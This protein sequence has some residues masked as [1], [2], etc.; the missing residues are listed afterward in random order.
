MNIAIIGTGIAG[1]Y[2]AYRLAQHHDITVFEASDRIGGHTN[3]L[4]VEDAGRMLAVDTGFIVYND[5]TYP[6][7]IA[8]LDELGVASQPSDMSFSVTGGPHDLEYNGSSLNGLFAQRRNLVRPAFY[9]MLVDILR[10]NREAPALLT[11]PELRL[12]LGEYLALNHYS[13]QFVENYILPMGSAIWS[14]TADRMRA[15]PAV[16]FVRFFQNH[17]L[18]SV[19]DRPQWRVIK[20]GSARYVEQLVAG[21]RDRIRTATPVTA[22]RRFPGHVEIRS[23]ANEAERFDR[24]FLACHS[25]QALAMLADPTP[26]ER[27]VLGAIE[28]QTN[29][30]VLH[31]DS[32]LMPKRR[33]AWAAWNY[34]IP[35]DLSAKD[36]K[37][38]LTY[39]MNI[40]QSLSATR[41]YCVTLN[42]TDAIDPDRVIRK[43]SYDHPIFT[44]RAVAAQQRQREINGTGQ[45]YYCGAYWRY[46]F[47]EDGVVSA[48]DALKHFEE[49]LDEPGIGNGKQRNLRRVG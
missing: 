20:G 40:L 32:S 43:I 4:E 9:R 5:L 8:L 10:F 14:A 24:V 28:Y 17:G 22:I 46:G 2:A 30:A 36:C 6:N 11:Q 25:D 18:L 29:E 38:T 39:N 45:T 23:A 48:I 34:N 49:D 42:N 35:K 26:Q 13:E 19:N 21:H 7:F 47:H 1:N 41:E 44:E 33:R 27:E 37:V 31:T 3:T 16:F 15:M 12:T